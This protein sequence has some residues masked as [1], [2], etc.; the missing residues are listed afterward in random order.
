MKKHCFIFV[1]CILLNLLIFAENGSQEEVDFLLFLPNS[2]SQFVN[3][4]RTMAHL[5]DIAGYLLGRNLYPGQ[6]HVYGYAASA[7]ND[8]DGDQLSRERALFVIREL[9]RRGLEEG[10][11]AEPAA[12]GSVDLWG[13]NEDEQGRS[14]NRRA[15]IILDGV[16]LTP[17][18]TPLLAP[19]PAPVVQAPEIT[20]I[21]TNGFGFPWMLLPIILILLAIILFLALKSRKKEVIEDNAAPTPIVKTPSVEVPPAAVAV[22]AIVQAPPVEVPPAAAM[23]VTYTV[24]NLEDEIRF[25]AFALYLERDGKNGDEYGDWCKAVAETCARYEAAGYETYAENESWWARRE[26]SS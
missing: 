13:S 3:H 16:V 14:P 5:D 20:R 23:A 8:I 2:A 24:V 1:F 6:I 25:R 4:D 15:R 22:A 18:D 9:Q 10:L 17:Q 12:F 7:A 26:S 19:I 21:N 11:F